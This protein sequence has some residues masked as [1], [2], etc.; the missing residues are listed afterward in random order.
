[1]TRQIQVLTKHLIRRVLLAHPRKVLLVMALI[2]GFLA[3][4]ARHFALDASSETLMLQNDRDLQYAREISRRY[5]SNDFLV[6]TYTPHDD[7][8]APATLT[9]LRALQEA[10][11]ALP[12]GHKVKSLLD[13]PLLESPPVPLKELQSNRRYLTSPDLDMDLAR[14][15]L[16][17]S[18]LYQQLLISPD[19]RTTALLINFP[20]NHRH[21]ELRTRRNTLRSLQAEAD[22]SPALERELVDVTQQFRQSHNLL[23]R[24][25]HE[26]IRAIRA[27]TENFRNHADLFLGGVSMISD[28]MITFIKSDLKVFGIGVL[29]FLIVTLGT[30]FRRIRWVILPVL[31]CTISVVC[32]VGLLAWFGWEVTVISSNFI[33]LQLILTMAVAIHLIVRYRELQADNPQADSHDLIFDTIRLKL[34]PCLYATL[35]TIA[36]FASL[37]LCDILPVVTFGWMMIAGLIVSLLVT[38][39]L[40]PAILALLPQPAPCTRRIPRWSFPHATAG[41]TRDRGRTIV[42]AGILALFFSLVGISQ[43][44]VENS[45]IDYFK[46]STEIYQGMSVIDRQLGGTTP[47]DV[48]VQFP[49]PASDA[50]SDP[51]ESESITLNQDDFDDFEAF[52]DEFEQEEDPNKYWFTHDKMDTVRAVHRYLDNLPATGKVLSL[53]T[54]LE[55]AKRLNEGKTLDSVEVALLFNEAPEELQELLITPYVSIDHNEVR[56]SARIID[57]QP[58]LRRNQ[59]LKTV[60]RDLAEQLGIPEDQFRLAGALVLYNNMLRSLY[61]S[62]ILTLALTILILLVMFLI[63]F[64][65]VKIALIALFPNVLSIAVVLG[66]MGWADIPLDMMTITIA[67]ISVGIAVDDTI[68]YIHRFKTEFQ[69]DHNYLKTME[70]CHHSIGNAMTYTSVTIILG[71]S[72]LALSNFI[73][74]IYFGLLTGLAMLIALIAALTLLP[75]LIIIVQ[76]FGKNAP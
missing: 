23:R 66:I 60:Q 12:G 24:Q 4:Q 35:T 75:Q 47:L 64:R 37:V 8:F 70:R 39:T 62:Q 6:L 14:R 26:D 73:P 71:F 10:L 13:I 25:R 41:L 27:V 20:D 55:M 58:G 53:A 16:Q 76:P 63:L 61:D 2:T 43:L 32:M 19:L 40:F 5:G 52:T 72:I 65:S 34:K 31:F 22:L 21:D 7:L 33:S 11:L 74:S 67:A 69:Q 46:K 1:M 30:I 29:V 68:H 57:S 17:Q 9:H 36:G 15:E 44:E 54:S 45:F 3:W 48:T 56:I 51:D 42:L 59:L 49:T 28:D 18:P 50:E 38:F